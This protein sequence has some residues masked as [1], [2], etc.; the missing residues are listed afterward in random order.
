MKK[1][2]GRRA[3][4]IAKERVNRLPTKKESANK[5]GTGVTE[6]E[7]DT[8][9]VRC[10][11]GRS[12]RESAPV[13]VAVAVAVAVAKRVVARQFTTRSFYLFLFHFVL[14][15]FIIFPSFENL[16]FHNNPNIARTGT[17]DW[18]NAKKENLKNKRKRNITTTTKRKNKR[19]IS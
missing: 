13:T 16:L 7:G 17:L 3:E 12:D 10:T 14:F 15:R 9:S 18:G 6:E 1:K 8:R 19:K 2:S 5:Q 4:E 11:T